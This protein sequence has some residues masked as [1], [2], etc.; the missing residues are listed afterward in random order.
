M[1]SIALLTKHWTPESVE[2]SLEIIFARICFIEQ[3]DQT[4]NG[5]SGRPTFEELAICIK[6]SLY[7]RWQAHQ[8]VTT[9]NAFESEVL[10]F[11]SLLNDVKDVKEI[12]IISMACYRRLSGTVSEKISEFPKKGSAHARY[13]F[14]L[15]SF[16]FL[17]IER[18]SWQEP[19]AE[20]SYPKI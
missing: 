8:A 4:F 16:D 11:L 17:S 13:R 2:K 18:T 15:V 14:T 10:I 12:R 19:N 20:R 3:L 7:T 6:R 1:K 9:F 5:Q